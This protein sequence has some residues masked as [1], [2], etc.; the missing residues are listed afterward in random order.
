M[1]DSAI[2]DQEIAVPESVISFVDDN[3]AEKLPTGSSITSISPH[4]AS[5]WTRTARIQT[6]D[7]DGNAVSYFL[8]V[9][10]SDVGRG[11]MHGEFHSM[12]ALY[13]SMPFLVPRPIASGSYAKD[14][15]ISFS[16]SAFHNMV[17]ADHIPDARTL[18]P[19]LADLHKTSV[20]PSGKFGFHMPTYQGRLPQDTTE[21]ETW[22]SSFS[23]GIA[24]FFELEE[25]AQG[26]DDEMAMLRKAVM[27]RVIPRLLRP[28]ETG[29]RKV[30]PR[31]VHG[32]L[33]DGN[34]SV[35]VETGLPIVFDACCSYAHHEYEL[36]PWRPTRHK[37]GKEYVEEYLKHFPAS[38]PVED[39]D[40]RNALYC[41]RFNLCSSALYPGNLY[42]RN[43]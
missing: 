24:R 34:A 25:E 39:F 35:N 40:D 7:A 10:Q 28:L 13:T 33:W 20:S 43:M 6:H 4:G 11:M 23:R 37:I 31:L 2:W 27:E 22:E 5:Y 9:S 42:F 17:N 19:L 21:C 3:V 38:D 8:K 14:A 16:L 15:D 32:D 30:V 12:S 26:P 29:G 41:V 18:A 36:A 1:V